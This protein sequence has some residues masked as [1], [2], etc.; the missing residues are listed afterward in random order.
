MTADQFLLFLNEKAEST[1]PNTIITLNERDLPSGMD[2]PAFV[3]N[4]Q[5]L[6]QQKKLFYK[7]ENRDEVLVAC[8]QLEQ[9]AYTDILDRW[10]PSRETINQLL[11]YGLSYQKCKVYIDEYCRHI[12]T[13]KS[14]LSF[15]HFIKEN[16][17]PTHSALFVPKNWLPSK[18]TLET[19]KSRGLSEEVIARLL[20]ENFRER[21]CFDASWDRAFLEISENLKGADKGLNLTP[22]SSG[23]IM[24]PQWVPT[25]STID[26]I[27]KD[28]NASKDQIDLMFLE[29]RLFWL[30]RG[31]KRVNWDLHFKSWAKRQN[32]ELFRTR[33]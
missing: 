7:I 4:L 29:Y 2:W 23:T 22:Q 16:Q 20:D 31:D 6:Q 19:L 3:I 13:E 9:V 28:T 26:E 11:S 17:T 27:L 21:L 24:S 30:E 18:E 25:E 33:R 12:K 32:P 15:I 14:D 8:V 1:H 5:V 10:Y